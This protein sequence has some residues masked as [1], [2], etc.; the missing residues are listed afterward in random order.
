MPHYLLEA[1]DV[2]LVTFYYLVFGFLASLAINHVLEV[3]DTRESKDEE[4]STI[5]LGVEITAH[6]L[7]L[8]LIFYFLRVL[9]RGIPFPWDGRRGYNHAA[10]YEIDGGIVLIVVILFFQ[11]RLIEKVGVFQNKVRE[12]LGYDDVPDS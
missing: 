7:V 2:L 10:L 8:A 11:R 3:L 12:Y 4:R 5:L 1:T 6:V 9:I